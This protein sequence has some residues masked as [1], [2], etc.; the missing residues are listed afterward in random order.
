MNTNTLPTDELKKYGIINEDL[1]FSKKLNAD[2][3]Q[4]FLKGYTIVAD[5]DKNRATFQLTDNNTQLKVIFLE[6]DKNLSEIIKN[7][8]VRVEYAN[9]QK[10]LHKLLPVFSTLEKKAFI[11]D[12]ETSKV[13]EFDFI[14]NAK[15]ITAI[16]ADKKDTEELNRYRTELLKMKS[17]LLDMINQYPEADKVITKNLTI[18][19]R[20]INTV[21]SIATNQKQIFKAGDSDIQLNGNAPDLY[22][23]A[24]QRRDD[25]LEQDE[26]VDKLRN[27]RR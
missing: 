26:E 12:K 13:V 14:K 18:V 5:N 21:D 8:M 1:S 10:L 27:F 23:N 17:F 2:D 25:D 4:K 15:E 7:S 20:E 6:R 19:S 16:I 3:I 11:F 24:N 9:V 22:Q